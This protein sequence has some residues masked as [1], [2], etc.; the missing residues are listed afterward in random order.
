M[1]TAVH[2]ARRSSEH[3]TFIMIIGDSMRPS[4][5]KFFST[6]AALSLSVVAAQA[7]SP[8]TQQNN[9]YFKDGQKELK[10]T[11]AQKPITKKAKN[12]ILFIGDGNSVATVTA[13]RILDGQQKGMTGG[14]Q[15]FLSFENLP[16]S[17]LAKTY[18]TD[19][20]IPD[21][22]G[23]ATAMLSGVKTDKGVLGVNEN[24]IRGEY[25]TIKGNQ[26][27][28]LLELAEQIGMSTGII[29]TARITHATPAAAYAHTADRNWA[30]DK[31][32]PAQAK[33]AGIKDIAWQLID[34]PYGDGVDVVMGGGRRSFITTDTIDEEGK[35]GKRTDGRNLIREWEQK[36]G[37][38]Y[39]WNQ[40]GFDTID[41]SS[42]KKILGLFNSSH[43]QY[44][45]D[46]ADDKGGE[47][48]LAEMT[49]KAIDILDNND[50]GYFML[51]ESGRIDH[52]NHATNAYRV[53]H[54]TIAF[55]DAIQA[56][57]DKVDMEETLIIVT[58][59]HSH[60]LVIQGYQ[61]RDKSILGLSD[62]LDENGVPYTVLA[63]TNGPGAVVGERKAPVDPEDKD[64]VQQSLIPL[65]SETHEGSDVTIYAGGPFAHLF[66]KTVEQSYIFHVMD[67][68]A[69]IS[70]RAAKK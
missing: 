50:Q 67:Y 42:N 10:A 65:S 30:T 34:M 39:I 69:D 6:M 70:K 5:L 31:Y 22:A 11:L 21:S 66:Q 12:I 27:P 35:K 17:A 61:S 68:A 13:A 58:A 52:A 60:T 9:P 24:I 16:Y 49:T 2:S 28:T 18:N 15:N 19:Q 23:T 63:Y 55:S 1:F 57:I 41:P 46:R 56:T 38:D 62:E 59:D 51:V 14:E 4:H 44:E 26:T 48:S 40:Q 7:H 25:T 20:R 36:T 8:L 3:T 54:D 29:S 33:E 37:G 64:Y 43:M 32:M 53:L 45:A 47:P